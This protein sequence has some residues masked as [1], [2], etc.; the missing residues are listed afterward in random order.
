MVG[1]VHSDK[2]RGPQQ[3]GMVSGVTCRVVSEATVSRQTVVTTLAQACSQWHSR[4]FAGTESVGLH[5]IRLAGE[6]TLC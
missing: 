4:W 2:Q 3:A 5:W 6:A 1:R